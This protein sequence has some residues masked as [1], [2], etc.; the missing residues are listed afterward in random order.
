MWGD[1]GGA[2]DPGETSEQTAAREFVE[3]SLCTVNCSKRR[4]AAR[5]IQSNLQHELYEGRF[6]LRLRLFYEEG[7]EHKLDAPASDD[8]TADVDDHHLPA[9]THCRDF[10]LKEIPFD[11]S[12]SQ[13]FEELRTTLLRVPEDIDRNVLPASIR[14]HPAMDNVES[15]V[16]S[17]FLEKQGGSTITNGL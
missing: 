9:R 16:G 5:N 14:T 1:L 8:Y 3:E 7:L 13:R 2:C 12:I 15:V 11:P 10:Y 6:F 4:Y 17:Q